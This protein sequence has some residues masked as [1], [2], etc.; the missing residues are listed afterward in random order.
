MKIGKVSEWSDVSQEVTFKGIRLKPMQLAII[1]C[2][3]RH[4]V[5]ANLPTGFGKSMLF[6][7]PASRLTRTTIL[8]FVPLKALLWDSLKEATLFNLSAAELTPA[9]IN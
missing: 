1:N 4:H 3:Q 6:Q 5:L 2:N 7:Y 9:F 8:V